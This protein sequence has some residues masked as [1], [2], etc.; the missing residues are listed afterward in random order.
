[1]SLRSRVLFG[2]LAIALVL[3]AADVA[4]AANVQRSLIDQID[5]RL[6]TVPGPFFGQGS[7]SFPGS[8]AP[9]PAPGGSGNG[10]S[11]PGTTSGDGTGTGNPFGRRLTEL[12][13]VQLAAD[14][15]PERD[16][17]PTLRDGDPKPRIDPQTA[18][19]HAV[20]L[21]QTVHPFTVGSEGTSGLRYRVVVVKDANGTYALIGT[22]MREADA[23]F[24]RLLWVEVAATGAVLFVLALVAFWVIR[25][26]VRPIDEMA[27]TADAIAEGD[28]SRRI[29]VV[30]PRTEAG[31]LG[32][33]L[34]GMLHQIE[35]AFS[36]RQESEDR[37]RRF[38]ADASHELRT[39]LTSIRGYTELYRSGAI[40]DGPQLVDAMRRIEGESERMGELVDDMLLL[41][42]LDQGRPLDSQLV[43]L[44]ALA[45]DAVA[46]ARAVEPDR[47]ISLDVSGPSTEVMGDEQRLRQMVGNLLANARQHTPRD[48]AVDVRV[49]SEDDQAMLEVADRGPGMAAEDAAHVFERFY[50]A[51]PSRVRAAEGG[52]VASGAGLGLSIVAAVA[53]AHHGR[54]W[55]ESA[56]GAGARFRIELPLAGSDPQP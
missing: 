34:N 17:P 30:S 42:R 51:D 21:G 52:I 16:L 55:V 14:G 53:S 41:A 7:G 10:S 24:S 39:P 9:S 22:S 36:E 35:G 47:P 48:A 54:A 32:M 15:T 44:D 28:L 56:P 23:T 19:A 33:A 40:T 29:D 12:Y 6:Q 31:R 50:R 18:I 25:L 3:I 43:D 2:F 1:M 5:H 37:L 49:W 26:C 13:F 27:A 46:D 20:T 4:L 45:A 38:V 11:S 8:N